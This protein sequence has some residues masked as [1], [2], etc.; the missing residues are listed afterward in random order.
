[1]N[2]HVSSETKNVNGKMGRRRALR[3]SF[4]GCG[5]VHRNDLGRSRGDGRLGPVSLRKVGGI[6]P[7]HRAESSCSLG[8]APPRRD[9]GPH[10]RGIDRPHRHDRAHSRGSGP[11]HREGRPRSRGSAPPYGASR[12][13]SRWI[14]P[15]HRTWAAQPRRMMS[16]HPAWALHSRSN[17]AKARADPIRGPP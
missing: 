14:G 9:G 8:I 16:F 1:M 15:P 17:P 12:P 3:G 5:A 6:A 13:Q 2:R 11:P 10:S 7:H 4:P